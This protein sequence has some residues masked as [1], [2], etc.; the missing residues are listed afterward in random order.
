MG[1]SKIYQQFKD[2]EALTYI[3]SL[4]FNTLCVCTHNI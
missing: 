4:A 2:V 3:K 1:L